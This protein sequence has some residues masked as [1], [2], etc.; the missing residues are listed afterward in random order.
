MKFID[1]RKRAGC[2]WLMPVILATVIGRITV[3]SQPRQIVHETLSQKTLYKNR[4]GRAAQGEGPEFK[5]STA[6]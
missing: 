2:W 6:K 4:A 3:L 1:I 5:S